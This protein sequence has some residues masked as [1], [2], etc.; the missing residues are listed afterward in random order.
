MDFKTDLIFAI[1]NKLGTTVVN[2]YNT[3]SPNGAEMQ[4]NVKL[5]TTASQKDTANRITLR[6][7]IK[8]ISAKGFDMV[9]INMGGSLVV[10]DMMV[11]CRRVTGQCNAMHVLMNP[12]A[13][14]TFSYGPHQSLSVETAVNHMRSTMSTL[15]NLKNSL[16][17]AAGSRHRGQII[18]GAPVYANGNHNIQLHESTTIPITINLREEGFEE[19]LHNRRACTDAQ[20]SAI[21]GVMQDLAN[22]LHHAAGVQGLTAAISTKVT[23]EI[24]HICTGGEADLLIATSEIRR[25]VA[26]LNESLTKLDISLGDLSR[27]STPVAG[28]RTQQPIPIPAGLMGPP[29]QPPIRGQAKKKR[30]TMIISRLIVK[31]PTIQETGINLAGKQIQVQPN[32]GQTNYTSILK[33]PEIAQLNNVQWGPTDLTSAESPE[34]RALAE[35]QR[36]LSEDTS[37]SRTV[38]WNNESYKTQYDELMTDIEQ[39]AE[40]EQAR[41]RGETPATPESPEA[42]GNIAEQLTLPPPSWELAACSTPLLDIFDTAQDISEE[43]ATSMPDLIPPMMPD[44]I[45]A[46][47]PTTR[48]VKRQPLTGKMTH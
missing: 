5:D 7:T 34:D 35:A 2:V 21:K 23:L 6:N 43:L 19:P 16:I 41:I 27:E 32:A 8:H 45:P 12:A 11:L 25:K 42:W 30:P 36:I 28:V 37:D 48:S 39:W 31:R 18:D 1:I 24:A 14:I 22:T 44:V 4:M 10:W 17:E 26:E 46:T 29:T 40:A 9:A 47:R 33:T 13:N 3:I 38:V 15:V 20:Q